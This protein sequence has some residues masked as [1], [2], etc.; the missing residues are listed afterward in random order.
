MF[1]GGIGI[2]EDVVEVYNNKVIQ[3]V[4]EDVVHKGLESAGNIYES[5]GITWYSKCP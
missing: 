4:L 3:I 1:F 2:D 5:K